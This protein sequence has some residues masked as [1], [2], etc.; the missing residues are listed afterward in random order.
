MHGPWRVHDH[1]EADQADGGAVD[2][3][4]VGSESV[5]NNAPGERAGDEDAAVGGEDPAEVRVWLKGGDE[6]VEA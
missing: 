3:V 2:V 5:E 1:G 4:S 6:A